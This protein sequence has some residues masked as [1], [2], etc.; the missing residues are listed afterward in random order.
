MFSLAPLL[1]CPHEA[2][3]DP[4]VEVAHAVVPGTLVAELLVGG[5]K[6]GGGVPAD[7]GGEDLGGLRAKE[8]G[9]AL[10]GLDRTLCELA[11]PLNCHSHSHLAPDARARGGGG[12]GVGGGERVDEVVP[13]LRRESDK[14]V[15]A[16]LF[17]RL[18]PRLSSH[19]S[20]DVHLDDAHHVCVEEERRRRLALPLVEA[21]DEIADVVGV[22]DVAAGGGD[23]EVLGEDLEV[24]QVVV[25]VGGDDEGGGRQAELEGW[26]ELEERRVQRIHPSNSTIATRFARRLTLVRMFVRCGPAYLS[27]TASTASSL[28]P[29]VLCKCS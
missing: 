12:A 1:V 16:A 19:L 17:A 24:H 2:L 3:E 14:G 5:G 4:G 27:I 18:K 20:P 25:H 11:R 26:G 8:S 28:T 15:S 13:A 22:E 10:L 21:G 7:A 6:L 29:P 9:C 23:E